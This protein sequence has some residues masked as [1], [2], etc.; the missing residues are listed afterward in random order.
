MTITNLDVLFN[1]YKCILK[2]HIFILSLFK[3]IYCFFLIKKWVEDTWHLLSKGKS[4]IIFNFLLLSSEAKNVKLKI[5][6]LK[7][8]HKSKIFVQIFCILICWR[9]VSWV[10]RKRF[11]FLMKIFHWSFQS[12]P[13]SELERTRTNIF[14]HLSLPFLNL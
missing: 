4:K 13:C 2:S 10:L 3:L 7:F 11:L 5:C 1:S 12:F 8:S 6:I 9:T 14:S